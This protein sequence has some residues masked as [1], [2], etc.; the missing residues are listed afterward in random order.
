[1]SGS[2]NPISLANPNS[3]RLA[4]SS[5]VPSGDGNAFKEMFENALGTVASAQADADIAVE[6]VLSGKSQDIHQA[7]IAT[8]K[9]DL[10]FQEFMAVKNKL[11]SAYATI[12][13]MQL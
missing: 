4:D 10:T 8:Q 12:M 2:I 13:G 3:I 7:M 1:M 6:G 11:T 9:A 5:P